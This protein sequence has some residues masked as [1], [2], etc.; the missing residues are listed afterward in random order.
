MSLDGLASVANGSKPVNG[1][2]RKQAKEYVGGKMLLSLE[3]TESVAHFVG[4]KQ[5]LHGENQTPEEVFSKL[6]EV[7]LDDVKQLAKR[8]IKS[9]QLRFGLIGDFD[10]NKIEAILQNY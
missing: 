10:Q 3:D 4:M 5:L 7:S 8:I 1:K 2:E 6:R 9:G